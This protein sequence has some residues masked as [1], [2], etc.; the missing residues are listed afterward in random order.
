MSGNLTL[1]IGGASSGKSSIAEK[2]C[3]LSGLPRIYLATAQVFDTEMRAKVVHHRTDRGQNWHTIE[4]PFEAAKVVSATKEGEVLLFDCATMWLTNHL[5]ADNNLTAETEALLTALTQSPAQVVIV[6]NEIGMG[7][8]PENALARRFR[9][10]Q[11]GLNSKLAEQCGTVI[12][13]MA[14]LPFALKGALPKG[15]T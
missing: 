10:A 6:S 3:V 7:V 15:I 4:E 14:G 12:G 13:V 8:V 9:I 5:L 11:G 2:I 1:V